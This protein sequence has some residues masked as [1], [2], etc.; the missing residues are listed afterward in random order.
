ML[1]RSATRE[2]RL[3]SIGGDRDGALAAIARAAAFGADAD[4]TQRWIARVNSKQSLES[5]PLT[6]DD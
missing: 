3:L 2:A 5:E 6:A 1:R 4:R